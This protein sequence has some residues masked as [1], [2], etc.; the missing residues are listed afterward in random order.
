MATT[1][2]LGTVEKAAIL[3]GATMNFDT[4]TAGSGAGDNWLF[5]ILKNNATVMASKNTNGNEISANTRYVLTNGTLANRT[6]AAGDTV[7]LRVTKTGNPTDLTAARKSGTLD[8]ARSF[9]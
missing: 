2:P 8:W 3:Q 6:C 4:G 9:G 1:H 7:E 5:E